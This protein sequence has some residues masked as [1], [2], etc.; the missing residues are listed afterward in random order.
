MRDHRTTHICMNIK[1]GVEWLRSMDAC[2]LADDI[3]LGKTFE[4]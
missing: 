2:V 4:L 3:G 1:K